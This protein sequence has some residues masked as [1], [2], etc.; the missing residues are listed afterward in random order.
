MGPFSDIRSWSEDENFKKVNKQSPVWEYFLRHIK[1][2]KAKCI[3]CD[4][5]LRTTSGQ[6]GSMW[7][8]LKLVH[9][10]DFG[11]KSTYGLKE[12]FADEEGGSGDYEKITGDDLEDFREEE[13]PVAGTEVE[14]FKKNESFNPIWEHFLR[15]T[16][17]GRAK[18][19]K[20][21]RIVSIKGGCTGPMR[22]HMRLVH[23]REVAKKSAYV[24]SQVP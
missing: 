20:C 7:T 5:I 6:T 3:K 23:K 18:C 4:R 17:G 9:K 1:G 19:I 11:T 22:T 14:N 21:H 24:N 10:M 12:I 16:D 15:H 13:V 8:H 2:G